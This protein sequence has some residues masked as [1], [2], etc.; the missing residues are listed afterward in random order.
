MAS[1]Q[2]ITIRPPWAHGLVPLGFMVF[3]GGFATLI[4]VGSL[5]RG[6]IAGVLFLAAPISLVRVR[7]MRTWTTG[8]Q[9]VDRGIW[10]TLHRSRDDIANFAVEDV[11]GLRFG[12]PPRRVV[13]LEQTDGRRIRINS[14]DVGFVRGMGLRAV[15]SAADELCEQLNAWRNPRQ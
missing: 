1:P 4:A 7:S 2:E 15:P 9:F 3:M 8:D 14:T 6:D 10:Q 13:V 12:L 11:K 5:V